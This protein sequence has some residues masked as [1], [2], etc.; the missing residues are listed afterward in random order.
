MLVQC[1]IIRAMTHLWYLRYLEEDAALWQ[2]LQTVE[3]MH[4]CML[5]RTLSRKDGSALLFWV[6]KSS[7]TTA[8]T[9]SRS[10]V[11]S[12]SCPGDCGGPM[13]ATECEVSVIWFREAMVR[14][15]FL[16]SQGMVHIV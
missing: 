15:P 4:H 11:Y 16:W 9:S 3:R 5:E 7:L 10:E 6:A 13:R 12:N 14:G 1:V 2:D 8:N